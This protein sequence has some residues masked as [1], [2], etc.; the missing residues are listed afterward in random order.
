[1]SGA[2]VYMLD[3]NA[4]STL[5]R[6]RAGAALQKLLTEQGACISV[7]TEAELRFCC[8]H[9]VDQCH[10]LPGIRRILVRR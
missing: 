7:I 4:A 8:A 6:G 3:T 10:V 2:Y 9:G 5:I 1:M